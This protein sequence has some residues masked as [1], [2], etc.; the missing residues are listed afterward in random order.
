MKIYAYDVA[1]PGV[2]M[3][4]IQ[5]LLKEEAQHA[6]ELY[7]KGI[8]RETY[9]RTDRPGALIVL[10]CADVEEAKKITDDLPLVKAGLIEFQFIPVG[11]FTPWESLFV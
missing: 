3:E 1:K 4:Q 5:P 11:P 7:K 9:L 2:G 10:E 8:M 6:W